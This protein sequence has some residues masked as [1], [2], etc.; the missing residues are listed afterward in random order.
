V[1]V[2]SGSPVDAASTDAMELPDLLVPRRTGFWRAGLVATC[3][4][5]PRPAAD[6][7]RPG[8][9]VTVADYFWAAPTGET[10]DVKLE[11]ADE[12]LGPC[13]S[14]EI[15]C[16][17]DRRVQFNW[18]FPDFVSVEQGPRASCGV[19]PDWTPTYVVRPIGDFTARL[20]IEAVLGPRA[21]A[22][23]RSAF[24]E[25]K[26][27]EIAN[28]PGKNG[29]PSCAAEAQFRPDSWYLEREHGRWHAQ[30]WSDTHRLCGYGFDFEAAVD[31]SPITGRTEAPAPW[32]QLAARWPDA[33]DVYS[34]PGGSWF[35]VETDR[36]LRV[37][38]ASASGTSPLATI[39][40][41][42]GE[43]LVMVEWATGANVAKW[44]ADVS[45]VRQ[46]PAPAPR[47]VRAAQ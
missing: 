34:T 24:D 9:E 38:A 30:G 44:A 23:F 21:I 5:T 32:D 16:D 3:A 7:R 11:S 6:D 27:R 15:S 29:Q 4:E 39:S 18:V 41:A 8:T 20:S 36:D 2:T 19:H 26:R 37:L 43:R 35:L 33:T 13:L 12:R 14:R 1:W 40:K 17:V 22:T 47:V 25:A 10:P 45:R 46:M 42:D 28:Q 31:L